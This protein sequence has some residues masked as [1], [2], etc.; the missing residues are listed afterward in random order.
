MHILLNALSISI[1]EVIYATEVIIGVEPFSSLWRIP[2]DE[3][4][5]QDL[6]T[7]YDD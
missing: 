4:T 3:G 7:S 2:S 1:V 5:A 6:V